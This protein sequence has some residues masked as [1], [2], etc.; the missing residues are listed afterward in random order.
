MCLPINGVLCWFLICTIFVVNMSNFVSVHDAMQ[1]RD[2]SKLA[3]RLL[4]WTMLMLQQSAWLSFSF[5]F[6]L[7]KL[8]LW[9]RGFSM[10]WLPLSFKVV[11]SDPCFI[12][13]Q[14]L[15]KKFSSLICVFK[16]ARSNRYVILLL[17]LY[18]QSW[19]KHGVHM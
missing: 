16:H 1:C 11:Q 12:T 9:G 4:N 2:I 14:K 13:S 17:C 15:F 5:F 10:L 18:Q 19:N 3:N 6:A 8:Y 7:G